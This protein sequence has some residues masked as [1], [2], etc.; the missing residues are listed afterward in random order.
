[1]QFFHMR[2]DE[3]KNWHNYLIIQVSKEAYGA[4][5]AKFE[6]QAPKLAS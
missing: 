2:D 4:L 6:E 1:M 5:K 3:S